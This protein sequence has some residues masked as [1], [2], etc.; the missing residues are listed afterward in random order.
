MLPP[1]SRKLEFLSDEREKDVSKCMYWLVRMPVPC[2]SDCVHWLMYFHFCTA[3]IVCSGASRL[4]D[5]NS[6]LLD[7][8]GST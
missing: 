1:S 2:C 8:G 3:Q 6:S 5:G 7:E 4:S